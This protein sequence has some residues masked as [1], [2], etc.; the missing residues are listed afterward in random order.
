MGYNA[1]KTRYTSNTSGNSTTAPDHERLYDTALMLLDDHSAKHAE[2]RK[3]KDLVRQRTKPTQVMSDKYLITSRSAMAWAIVAQ[4]RSFF[5]RSTRQIEVMADKATRGEDKRTSKNERWLIGSSAMVNR[6]NAFVESAAMYYG[7]ELGEMILGLSFNPYLARQGKFPLEVTAPDPEMCAYSRSH[8]GLTYFVSNE[9]RTVDALRDELTQLGKRGKGIYLPE[10]LEDA[11]ENPTNVLEDMRLYTKTHEVR[12]IDGEHVYS[13]KHLCGRVPFDIAYLY[14]T[15]SDRP[16]EWGRG[17][18]SPVRDLLESHQQ[19]LDLFVTDAE[20][21]ARPTGILAHGN[22]K[23]EIVQLSV[24]ETYDVDNPNPNAQLTP[25]VLNANHQLLHELVGLIMEQVDTAAMPRST[26]TGPAFQLSGFA[27]EKYSAG[28]DARVEDLKEYPQMALGSHMGLRLHIVK[29]YATMEAAKRISPDDP[30]L[31]LSSFA[32]VDTVNVPSEKGEKR[33]R[34]VWASLSA[35]D[36]SDEPQ[37]NVSLDP[38]I[39]AKNSQRIQQLQAALAAGLPYE[40]AVREVYDAEN[41]DELLS[42]HEVEVLVAGNPK[43]KEFYDEYLQKRL[44]ERDRDMRKEFEAWEEAQ[45]LVDNPM[46]QGD[47][48]DPLAGGGDLGASMPPMFLPTGQA[49]MGAPPMG[50]PPQGMLG[51]PYEPPMDAAMMG[52]GM[53]PPMGM[54]PVDPA[55][56]GM[57]GDEGVPPMSPEELQQLLMM[58]QGQGSGMPQG[59]PMMM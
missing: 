47:M 37:V 34:H 44:L 14:D 30:E 36:V 53:P 12:W 31:Y 26:F 54:P 40:Y 2:Q 50:M 17:V 20:L 23:F 52:G 22:G 25:I 3:I 59:A 4:M 56:L 57:T 19:L 43:F 6:A 51:S 24:G 58:L 5:T 35:D 18:I 16:E 15:P 28:I 21:G 11:D 27:L 29:Q 39:P 46:A 10:C 33:K 55:M 32:V 41:A 45:G 8:Y 42:Q 48:L 49:G 9:T 13:R 38:N 1:Q 7:L